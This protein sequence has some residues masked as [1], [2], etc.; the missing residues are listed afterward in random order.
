[1][2]PQ[3]LIDAIVRQT[4]VLIARI[5]TVE[6]VRS[7]LGHVA[8]EVFA[9]LVA[10]LGNQGVSNKVIADMFGMALRSYR[11]KVRRLG[12]SATTRGVTL[13]TA[14]QRFLTEHGPATRT[15]VLARF[16]HD[17]EVSIRGILSDLVESGLVVR[18]GRG[19]DTRY[20]V[21]TPEEIRDAGALVDN[22]SEEADAALVWVLVYRE[23]PLSLE[24]LS[25]L[26]P[27][28]RQ[29]LETALH[30]LEDRARIRR[31]ITDGEAVFT[32]EQVLI[33]LDEAAGWEASVI[34]HYQATVNA[35]AAKLSM[36]ARTSTASDEV[37]GTT[38][39]FDLW[40]G[41][42]REQEIR[43]LLRSTRASLL[44]LWEDVEAYNR[45]HVPHASTETYQVH[46]YCGQYVV[47]EEEP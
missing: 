32:A 34:D 27:L 15:Q 46:F 18:S 13:W 33:P 9:G 36:P 40:P 28:S 3:I 17:E 1:M 21:A 20:R 8:N 23:G 29:A 12:E 47:E 2:N 35:L 45:D 26:V 42:P 7:P 16:M 41:H 38:L 22:R 39:T 44:P 5:A 30:A 4:T 25:Q 14:V 11:Q 37:G 10:E 19:D 31:E 43:A 6:G 24:Q